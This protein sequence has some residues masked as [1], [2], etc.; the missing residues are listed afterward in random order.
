MEALNIKNYFQP[1]PRKEKE[2][3]QFKKQN[4]R[5]FRGSEVKALSDGKFVGT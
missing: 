3:R 2:T 1:S 5:T 4:R